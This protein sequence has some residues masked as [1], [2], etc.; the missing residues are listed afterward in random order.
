MVFY[1]QQPGMVML[2]DRKLPVKQPRLREKNRVRAK[3]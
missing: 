2:S 3:K 1:G